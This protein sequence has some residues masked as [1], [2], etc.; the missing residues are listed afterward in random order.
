M[1]LFT[2]AGAVGNVISGVCH[3]VCLSVCLCVYSHSESKTAR[4][5]ITKLGT[6]YTLWQSLG[7]R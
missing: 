5:M 7:M 2:I 4:A 3:C 1:F 6:H